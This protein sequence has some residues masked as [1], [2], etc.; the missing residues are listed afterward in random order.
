MGTFNTMKKDKT[1]N[2]VETFDNMVVK[3]I[4]GYSCPNC[5]AIC[6]QSTFISKTES[7]FK[8]EPDPHYDWN[9]IHKCKKCET[10]YLLHNGT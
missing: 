8:E 9:E 1:V 6:S 10:T 3:S 2:D 7:E 5:G 4:T